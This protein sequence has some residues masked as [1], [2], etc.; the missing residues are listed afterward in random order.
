VLTTA[1]TVAGF[2]AGYASNN[3]AEAG[4]LRPARLE[5]LDMFVSWGIGVTRSFW[6]C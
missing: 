4:D 3:L 5:K 2:G 6:A 1:V